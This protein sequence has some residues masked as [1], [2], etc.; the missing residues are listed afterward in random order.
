[1][2]EQAPRPRSA[3][4]SMLFYHVVLSLFGLNPF[5]RGTRVTPWPAAT[6]PTT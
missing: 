4:M 2:E 6:R 1:M 5:L 3:L